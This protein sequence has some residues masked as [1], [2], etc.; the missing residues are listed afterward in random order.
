[1]DHSYLPPDTIC[2]SVAAVSP[3]DPTHMH[4]THLL[5]N[6][7]TPPATASFLF[8]LKESSALDP[9]SSSFLIFIQTQSN[10][11]FLPPSLHKNY[12][13]QVSQ[14]P[15]Y[16]QIQWLSLSPYLDLSV[17]FYIADHS[18][19]LEKVSSSGSGTSPSLVLLF[20][21]WLLL[22][23]FLCW[24]IFACSLW[25]APGSSPWTWPLLCPLTPWRSPT[26]WMLTTLN[27]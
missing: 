5:L 20:C 10:Q 7:S 13:C 25:S 22:L 11:C 4:I 2:L 21:H 12:T 16:C 1:M 18:V 14:W 15:C 3:A 9:C 23:S 17:A 8:S 24:L 27:V 19:H 26:I 6:A